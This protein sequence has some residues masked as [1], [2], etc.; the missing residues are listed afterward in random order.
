M[1]VFAVDLSET[2]LYDE[3]MGTVQCLKE[4]GVGEITVKKSRFI[5]TLKPVETEEEAT[6]FINEIKKKYWDA[7]HNCSAF[8][9]GENG[10]LNRCSD[11][12]EPAG[13]AGRPMLEVL[14]G[15]GITNVCCVVTRYFGG[16][17]LGTGGLIRAYQGAVKEGLKQSVIVTR[18]SGTTCE[19][20]TDYGNVGKLQSLFG[21][22]NVRVENTDFAADVIFT[23]VLTKEQEEQIIRQI[24]DATGGTAAI[25]RVCTTDVDVPFEYSEDGRSD[26]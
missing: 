20:K 4:G 25:E 5:A 23:I 8:V 7:K 2:F 24:T 13:T 9:V 22:E 12:G 21:K 3:F 14:Q 16:T 11:D 10:Q 6:A 1:K 15:I 17:L 19:I 26:M 18:M